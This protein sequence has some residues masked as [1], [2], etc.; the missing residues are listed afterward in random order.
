[1]PTLTR[2]CNWNKTHDE[3]KTLGHYQG[4]KLSP[5][6]LLRTTHGICDDCL[7]VVQAE[8]RRRKENKNAHK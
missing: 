7:G 6:S 2:V 5:M 3:P 4:P 1:M 8:I